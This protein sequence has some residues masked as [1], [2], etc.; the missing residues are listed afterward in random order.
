MGGGEVPPVQFTP[1]HQN[2]ALGELWVGEFY[3]LQYDN[4]IPDIPVK[5]MNPHFRP[6]RRS[7]RTPLYRA[8]TQSP[9]GWEEH[10]VDTWLPVGGRGFPILSTTRCL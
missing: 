1:G 6:C 3:L 2:L 8:V 4:G 7:Y 5:E 10:H 9:G